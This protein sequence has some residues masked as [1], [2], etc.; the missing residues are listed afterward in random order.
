MIYRRPVGIPHSL[1][2]PSLSALRHARP[3]PQIPRLCRVTPLLPPALT[4]PR[5]SPWPLSPRPTASDRRCPAFGVCGPR[6]F[7]PAP[8]V[9]PVVKSHCVPFARP[10][11]PPFPVFCRP[12]DLLSRVVIFPPPARLVSPAVLPVA[13]LPTAVSVRPAMP[14]PFPRLTQCLSNDRQVTPFCFP[15]S[16]LLSC[17]FPWVSAF[18]FCLLSYAPWGSVAGHPPIQSSPP[19]LPPRL[20]PAWSLQLFSPLAPQPTADSVRLVMPTRSPL[21]PIAFPTVAK[22]PPLSLRSSPS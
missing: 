14:I 11:V 16:G 12:S 3:P 13:S 2:L 6:P 18:S 17:G 20:L 9:F 8:P 4:P 5:W 21:S 22:S 15:F 1:P 10:L 19:P 7:A